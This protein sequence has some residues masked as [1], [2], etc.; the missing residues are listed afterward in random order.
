MV[1]GHLDDIEIKEVKN[2]EALKASMKVLVGPD[3]GWK[4]NVM[5]TFE[6]EKDGYTPKHSHPWPHINYIIEGEGVLFLNGKENHVKKGSFAF[7]PE[8]E[9]HQFKNVGDKKFVFICIVP[10][11]GHK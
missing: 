5:R 3:E 11:K 9:L 7:V 4:G 6:L 2:P 10:E 1:I 8:N